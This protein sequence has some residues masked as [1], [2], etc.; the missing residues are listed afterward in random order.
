[1]PVI[2]LDGDIPT[3]ERPRHRSAAVDDMAVLAARV[4]GEFVEMPGLRLSASQAA[5]LFG[6]TPEVAHALLD[7][8]RRALV[9]TCSNRGTYSLVADYSRQCGRS[10]SPGDA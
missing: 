9:L 2:A 10:E 3:P 7:D 1:M 6:V 8:L 5:R 4:R